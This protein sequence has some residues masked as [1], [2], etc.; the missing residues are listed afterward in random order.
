MD[1]LTKARAYEIAAAWHDTQAR[2]FCEM[3][4]DEPRIDGATRTRAASAARHHAGSAAALRLAAS[5]LFRLALN[6]EQHDDR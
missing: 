2:T 5:N 6:G 4:H 3:A 1:M